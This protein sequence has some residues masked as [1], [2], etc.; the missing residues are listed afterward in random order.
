MTG[1]YPAWVDDTATARFPKTFREAMRIV[2]RENPNRGW[3]PERWFVYA[4]RD[5]NARTKYEIY[6][7]SN[8]YLYSAYNPNGGNTDGCFDGNQ[9]LTIWIDK[10]GP[11]GPVLGI[12]LPK[13]AFGFSFTPDR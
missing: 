8:I 6:Y 12:G 9:K 3:G 4:V 13:A 11:E 7:H 1:G 10:T 2:R 5:G